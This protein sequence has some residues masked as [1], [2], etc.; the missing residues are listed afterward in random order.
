[1]VRTTWRAVFLACDVMLALMDAIVVPEYHVFKTL[2]D[3]VCWTRWC[4][5]QH[6]VA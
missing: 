1:V 6:G 4:S 5:V 2:S 3:R